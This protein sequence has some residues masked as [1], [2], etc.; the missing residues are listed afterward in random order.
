MVRARGW[1][2]IGGTVGYSVS[3]LLAVIV[4]AAAGYAHYVQHQVG[5]LASSNVDTGGPQTGAM[6]ILLM[7]LESRTDYNGNVLPA[8]LL[9]AM[10]AGSVNGVL[11]KGVGGQ[12][13]WHNPAA[14]RLAPP[15]CV[16]QPLAQ[17]HADR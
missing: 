7:G 12:Q 2:T 14:D 4:L 6:N 10:H 1:R 16:G 8:G 3:C 5:G 11:H 15:P 13:G 17:Q 9:A